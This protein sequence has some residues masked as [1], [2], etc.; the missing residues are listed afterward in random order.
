MACYLQKLNVRK[1]E[2]IKL[3]NEVYQETL[4]NP[5]MENIDK[6]NNVRVDLKTVKSR[7]KNYGLTDTYIEEFYLPNINIID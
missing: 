3:E 7:I 4:K 1:K 2:L 6:L 5:T